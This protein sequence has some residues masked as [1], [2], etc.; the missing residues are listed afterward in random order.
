MDIPVTLREFG[1]NS[2]LI[3]D[4]AYE[5]PRP[6]RLDE[7][8]R[9][10]FLDAVRENEERA[11][12]IRQQFPDIDP[13][14]PDHAVRDLLGGEGS[15]HRLWSLYREQ[16]EA[17]GW[18]A[19]AFEQFEQESA[20]KRNSI[21]G[22]ESYL[23]DRNF[24]PV[25]WDGQQGNTPAL[26]Q[27]GLA[28]VDL[29]LVERNPPDPEADL[30]YAAAIAQRFSKE[31]TVGDNTLQPI[32]ILISSREQRAREMK[33][34]FREQSGIKGSF[35]RFL[36]KSALEDP[37][38]IDGILEEVL[39]Q[40][41]SARQL[42]TYLDVLAEAAHEAAK[43]ITVKL[44]QLELTDLA[45]LNQ[46]R[47][48]P[49]NEALGAYCNWLFAEGTSVAIQSAGQVRKASA[50]VSALERIRLDGHIGP[51]NVLFDLYARVTARTD[52]RDEP[53]TPRS[54][55]VAFGDIFREDKVTDGQTISLFYAALSPDCA[56]LRANDDYQVLCVTG[57]IGDRVGDVKRWLKTATVGNSRH[58]FEFVE[59]G[60]R[61]F[62]VI[63]W[64]LE[65]IKTV[66][67]GD[68]RSPVR[69]TRLARLHPLFSHQLKEDLLRELGQVALPITPSP[70]RIY[71]SQVLLT[72]AG[73]EALW[74]PQGIYSAVLTMQHK[75]GL[76]RVL[77]FSRA[78]VADLKARVRSELPRA[79]VS[80]PSFDRL[81]AACD[82]DAFDRIAVG[83]DS[84]M[85][86]L[87]QIGVRI[88]VDAPDT[89][90][91]RPFCEITLTSVEQ[92]Q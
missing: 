4:D 89:G 24:V 5:L 73:A 13:E 43:Q 75:K 88:L 54:D 50:R 60:Q 19:A 65:R 56:M 66:L 83:R 82:T 47:L 6:S 62:R 78:F 7:D 34:R 70:M 46:L 40:Y 90:Q 55:P 36:E 38:K 80:R 52:V 42:A 1:I 20:L 39:E 57:E 29:F 48:V 84:V 14:L 26:G 77:C 81:I 91:Q 64:D 12:Q 15:V 25:T 51:R 67:I 68:L 11:E 16:R 85:T 74:T 87:N 2:V 63:Q 76:E 59:G 22:L 71:D 9:A 44:G 18:L 32:V 28:F 10:R 23:H 61:V 49:E 33:E 92:N 17:Y 69:F 58:L 30:T 8:A 31:R 53:G 3:V 41:S 37:A 27:V 79:G 21:A 72:F 35:F 45:L 86:D